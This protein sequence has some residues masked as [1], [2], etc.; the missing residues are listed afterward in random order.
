MQNWSDGYMTEV[1]YTFGYYPE[2]NPLRARLALLEAG[3]VPP[4]IKNAC[5]LGFGQ[6]VSVNIHQAASSADWHGTD[7]NPAQVGFARELAQ[8]TP[9]AAR[10]SDEAFDA[11][12]DRDD[13]PQFD[14]IALHGIWSWISDANRGV[15]ARFIE[16]HLKV[17]GV[18]Y[19]SY[20]TQPGWAAVAP[21]TELMAGFDAALNP[22]GI[23]AAAR[24]DAAL[25]FVDRLLESG[26]LYGK[27][28]PQAIEHMKRLRR[29]DRRYLAHEYFNRDWHPMSFSRMRGWM[30]GAKL[31]FGTSAHLL[32]HV[33]TLNFTPDQ[34]ALLDG[35]TDAAYRETTRDF[36]VN[37]LFRRDLWLRGVRRLA[38]SERLS[39]LRAERV[40]LVTPVVGVQLTVTGPLGEANL[41]EDIYRPILDALADHLPHSLGEIEQLV[42]PRGIGVARIVEA[43]MILGHAG[44]VQPAQEAAVIER[45]RAAVERLNARLCA[46]AR[47]GEDIAYL[48]SP[49]TGG[50]IQVARMDQ[51]F[52]VAR[53]LGHGSAAAWAEFASAALAGEGQRVIR[54][55]KPVDTDAQQLEVLLGQARVFEAERLP[56]LLALG[57]AAPVGGRR[58]G[59]SA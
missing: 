15:I 49:V 52:L 41:H 59:R 51:L 57:V 30:E 14:Y 53:T 48:A 46:R 8:D 21:I 24:I 18:V 27:A 38:P 50:G 29:H 26:A 31:Q 17:G 20:N 3:I 36:I 28:N 23:G 42:A 25:D 44:V 58:R 13:L 47:H 40:V 5:E 12:A 1:A 2:L 39:R 56:L 22:A 7:F 37:K 33:P 55:G 19:V 32:D 9:L 34:Q 35:T 45:A 6:G 11:F 4:D 43:I 54:D 10:L 16:R